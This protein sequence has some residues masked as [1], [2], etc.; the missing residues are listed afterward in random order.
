MRRRTLS[1]S[2]DDDIAGV[3][4]TAIS[5]KN[6]MS[7]GGFQ[8]RV[9][10]KLKSLIPKACPIRHDN[11]NPFNLPSSIQFHIAM[12]CGFGSDGLDVT[13]WRCRNGQPVGYGANDIVP[14]VGVAFLVE[15]N[16]WA[17]MW[18]G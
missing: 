14:L 7:F 2:V 1:L 4:V 8:C 5:M 6:G 9:Y 18:P 10:P 11:S 3:Q 12:R 16:N 15:V 13:G 17:R